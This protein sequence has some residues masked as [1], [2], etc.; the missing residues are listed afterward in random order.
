VPLEARSKAPDTFSDGLVA[1]LGSSDG[2]GL[3][4]GADVAFVDE[5]TG[6]G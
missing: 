5:R 4:P 2:E 3:L 6:A 1:V